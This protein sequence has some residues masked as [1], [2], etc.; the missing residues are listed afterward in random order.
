ME[1]QISRRNFCRSSVL[2][3]AAGAAPSVLPCFAQMPAA[4][5]RSPIRLGLASYTFRNFT[6]SQMIGFIQQL[7]INALNAKDVKD[8]L[9]ADPADEARA[10]SDYTRAGI[11]LHAAG[12]IY[13]GKD[14]DE[15]IRSKFEYAKRAGIE[16]IVAGDPS[17]G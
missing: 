1:N 6:R 12:A 4:R 11:H 9:P 10:I 2:L 8:H 17:P 3:S 5:N 16:V 7:N 14:E 15:D 13:F